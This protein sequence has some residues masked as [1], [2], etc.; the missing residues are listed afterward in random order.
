MKTMTER[1]NI[2][3]WFLISLLLR[4]IV[5]PFTMHD[6]MMFIYRIPHLLLHSE[7]DVYGISVEQFHSHYYPPFALIFFA[8]I[9]FILGFLFPGFEEFT[10]AIGL[11]ETKALYEAEHFYL[12]VFLMKLPYLFFDCFLILVCW[13]ML[14][15]NKSKLNFTIFWAVNPLVIYTTFMFGQFDLIPAFFV[16]LACYFSLQRGREQYACLCIASGCLFKVFPIVFLPV[17]L[18]IS[19]RN[20]KDFF[21]FSLYGIVPV[22][23]F[24]G[25]FYLISGEATLRLFSAFSYNTKM[26]IDF[27][28]VI[29]RFSQATVYILLCIH[30]ILYKREQLNYTIIIQYFLVIYL[31]IYWGLQLSSTH[32]LTWFV[33]FLI[34]YV[35]QRSDWKK[36]FYFLLLIIFLD[37]LKPRTGCLGIFAP[38]NPEFFLSLPS[39]KDVTGFLFDQKTYDLTI[40]LLFKGV[41][42]LWVL[43]ILKNLYKTSEW[44]TI[45]NLIN[46]SI[47]KKY[48]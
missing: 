48:S 43:A 1:F 32:Y 46:K 31:A 15:S 45:D 3:Q 10:H 11:L 17:V 14:P 23:F 39:L 7:L 9:Q 19:S 29:L 26:F 28:T 5:M 40:G 24:Y 27:K 18:L 33:P 20:I 44:S 21:R 36:P 22:L 16:V 25:V 2:K 8:F 41:T 13:R 38:I 34:L 12:S 6:D 47:F 4:L 37:G 42:G 35:Q 30:L